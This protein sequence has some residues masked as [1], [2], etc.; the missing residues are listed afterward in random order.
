MATGG[1]PMAESGDAGGGSDPGVAFVWPK[2][3]TGGKRGEQRTTAAMMGEGP[4]PSP[5]SP[6]TANEDDP[7]GGPAASPADREARPDGSGNAGSGGGRLAKRMLGQGGTP[8]G[9]PPSVATPPPSP[10][11][12]GLGMPS[13]PSTPAGLPPASTPI[14]SPR[15]LPALP[16]LPEPG[17]K[18]V[19][20][21]FEVVVVCGSRGVVVQ[22]G[23]YRVTSDAL[24]DRDG[25]FKK[26]IVGLVKARRSADPKV[27]VEP[28][29]RFL[30]QPGGFATYRAARAQFLLSGLDWP[31]SF[32]VADPDPLAVLP[33]EG[34]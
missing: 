15:A 18:V 29:I 31:A 22:P 33:S 25:L 4:G 21:T 19:D 10:M 28:K 20:R 1:G 6:A 17:P 9:S 24:R 8:G 14:P 32:H 27:T 26:Q 7:G 13:P 5:R 3:G 16:A 11:R 34:W 23:G 30:V 2:D 12:L